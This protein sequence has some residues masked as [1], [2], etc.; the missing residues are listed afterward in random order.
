MTKIDAAANVTAKDREILKSVK[1]VIEG[2]L[3]GAKVFLYGSVARG[4]RDAES[5]YDILILTD[6]FLTAAEEDGVDDAVY[7]IQLAHGVVI[8]TLFYTKSEW[9]QP[10]FRGMPFRREVEKDGVLL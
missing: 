5:D 4:S 3:P 6:S 10:L 9:D 8:S 2:H 1:Q 7:D